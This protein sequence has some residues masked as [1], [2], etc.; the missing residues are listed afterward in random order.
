MVTTEQIKEL[1]D[2]T[3]NSIMQCQKA[4]IEANGD[5]DKAL[6]ILRKKGGDIAAKKADRTL[7]ASI[8]HSYV[9]SNS[10]VGVLIELSCETDFVAKHEDFKALAYDIAMHITASNPEFLKK[11]DV[12]AHA[13]QAAMEVFEGEVAAS[14]KP[15]EMQAKI[16]EGKMNAYFKDK[17]LME[18]A[19]IKNPDQTIGDLISGA[20]QKFGEKTEIT[21]FSRFASLEK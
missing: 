20:V 7:G 11:E 10:K 2:E 9:H 12:T 16:L 1:R 18:Q 5:K 21:R 19:F 17:I 15:K 8:I 13:K 6:V 14:G 3:G 4:L